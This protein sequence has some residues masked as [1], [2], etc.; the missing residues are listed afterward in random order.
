MFTGAKC[1][2][3]RSGFD[4]RGNVMI[5]F[6]LALPMLF[7]LLT[8]LLDLGRYGMQKSAML[9]GAR[10]GAMYGTVAPTDSANINS[11]AQTA[12]SLTGVTAT[13]TVFCQCV[14]G[15]TV[16]C[17]STCGGGNLKKYITVTAT[18]SFTSVLSVATLNFGS[19]GSFTPPTSVTASITMAVP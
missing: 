6:A 8:G 10:D 17:N 15:T 11:T 7:L 18:R 12:T 5:E 3:L 9:G 19:F 4:D 16:A 1:R 2:R 14:A 13:N